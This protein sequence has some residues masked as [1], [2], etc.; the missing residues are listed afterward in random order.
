MRIRSLLLL[1]GL[2]VYG[3]AD[4]FGQ[5]SKSFHLVTL[6]DRKYDPND[7]FIA[8]LGMFHDQ[9]YLLYNT[10]DKGNVMAVYDG[11]TLRMIP[12]PDS[13][14]VGPRGVEGSFFIFRDKV[15][16]KY[17]NAQYGHCLAEYD[18]TSFHLIPNPD[19]QSWYGGDT[20]PAIYNNN[21]YLQY[22]RNEGAGLT[23]LRL[24]KFDGKSVS[25]IELNFEGQYLGSPLVCN[26][27][28]YFLFQVQRSEMGWFDGLNSGFVGNNDNKYGSLVYNFSTLYRK[29]IFAAMFYSNQESGRQ[30][31]GWYSFD[32]KSLIPIP[33][34][35]GRGSVAGPGMII[36]DTLYYAYQFTS[37]LQLAK[38]DGT[39]ST[40][41][42]NTGRGNLG[43]SLAVYKGKIY[44]QYIYPRAPFSLVDTGVLARV[45]GASMTVIP[46]PASIKQVS[47][48]LTTYRDKLY[49]NTD[50]RLAEYNGDTARVIDNDQPPY[51]K[52]N[53]FVYQDRLFF[54]YG[55]AEVYSALAYYDAVLPIAAIEPA[56]QAN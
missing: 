49:F 51:F 52:S 20:E 48:D 21:L 56:K 14:Q 50:S 55:N 26:G 17:M 1:C 30:G 39:T 18:G 37:G 46:L 31:I 44:V 25:L 15:Y 2:S 3:F 43:Y 16:V 34:P 54:C 5:I 11:K 35:K 40:A 38:Y 6:A 28:L 47:G 32:G 8:R 9:L 41:I 29:K 53:V 7:R 10:R 19:K 33:N 22:K 23:K 4:S 27:K 36:N 45:D 42:A 24:A 13:S 12:N